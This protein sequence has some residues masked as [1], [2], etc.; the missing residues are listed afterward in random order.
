VLISLDNRLS[1]TLLHRNYQ[2][3]YQNLLSNGFSENNTTSN[4]KGV[5]IG[6]ITKPTKTTTITAYRDSFEFPWL[7]YQ[8][9]APSKGNDYNIQFN[10][11]PSKKMDFYFRIQETNKEKNSTSNIIVNYLIPT[12]QRNYRFHISYDITTSLKLKNRIELINYQ[13]D[14]NPTE[15]G[16]LVYQDVCYNKPGKPLAITIRY[17]LFETDNYDTRIY[18]YENDV[19]NSYSIPSYYSRGSRF[20]VLVDYTISR[21]IELWLR[22]A[23]TFY[24][25]KNSISKGSLNE[26]AGNTKSEIKV[27]VRFKF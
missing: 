12:K 21:Q 11:T 7:K 22:Y 27:Q 10:Y 1:I 6:I 18:A 15:K 25:N 9:T 5:Y 24:D 8:A 20:Y 19:L 14:N 26:I 4:E 23:Q 17:A 13:Q 3:N 2:R 16:F